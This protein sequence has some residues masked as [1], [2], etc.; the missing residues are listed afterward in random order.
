MG[1]NAQ[2][3]ICL[4]IIIISIVLSVRHTNHTESI[5]DI[6]NSIIA[7]TA[8]IITFF[9]M[10]SNYEAVNNFSYKIIGK[11]LKGA[12]Q[13]KGV[14]N[15][16]FIVLLFCIIKYLIQIILSII[17]SLLFGNIT[18]NLNK[19]KRKRLFTISFS[20]GFGFIR[21]LVLIVLICIPLVLYNNLV[22][23]KAQ[24]NIF[25]GFKTY[26]KVEEIVDYKKIEVISDGIKENIASST[27]YYNG[28]TIEQGI[29]SNEEIEKKAKSIVKNSENDRDKALMFYIWIGENIEYD[30]EKAEEILEL[31]NKCESGAIP[32]FNTRK[33][34]CFD[35]SCLYTAMC[36]AVG[37]ETK[38]IIGEGYNGSEFVSHA[39]NEVY[40]EDEDKWIRVD[41]TFYGAGN[42]FDSSLFDTNHIKKSEISDF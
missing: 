30:N 40:L 26:E 25:D 24:I 29:A 42:Y 8:T 39:W 5:D 3:L 1:V 21:G 4:V 18:R 23:V 36:K 28:I 34:I 38:I 33:G 22:G 10:I 12:V 16:I 6:V 32:T 37:L 7:G 20:I 11:I 15:V 14:I 27:T 2:Q 19:S 13:Y 41:T 17:Q 31:N 9:I 35:Y